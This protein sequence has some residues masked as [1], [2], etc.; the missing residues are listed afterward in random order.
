MAVKRK[1]KPLLKIL[2]FFA[3]LLIGIG[4]SWIYLA[5]PVDSNSD[6]KIEVV[7]EN[8]T[9][10][11]GIASIL[12]EKK[13]IKS[14]YLFKIYIKLN[15]TKSLKASTYLLS[16][17][18]SLKEIINT[19]EGGSTYNPN[20]IKLTFKEGN[21]ITDYAKVISDNTNHSYDE[22]I[23]VFKDANYTKELINKYWFLTDEIINPQIYYSLEGY[24]AP[25]TYYFD[26]KDVKVKDIIE[27]M[28]D[29]MD[30]KLSK[31]KDAIGTNIHYYITMASIVELEGTNL[32]NRKMIV[33]VFKNR[34]ANKMNLGSDVT[35]YYGVQ[36]SMNNDLT[37]D[38]LATKN[39]YN[40]RAADMIGKMPVGPICSVSQ[41]SLD[42]SINPSVND[43]FYFVA[44][45]NGKIYYTKTLNE[46]N[47]KIAEIKANGDWI[48]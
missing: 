18:M 45:K 27:T 3:I 15:K 6:E 33:G 19:L 20:M 39:G 25:D 14:E 11:S 48:W 34:L 40:T 30:K 10:S 43:Y 1:A 12:K 21:R 22:V 9:T 16:K 36:A 5:S 4:C 41:S 32:E 29:E 31:Y 35:T 44:D 8:G 37:S 46:H 17:N 26:N 23:A 2:C 42:A 24:L 47:Q 7:I 28:L 38:Q 13:L